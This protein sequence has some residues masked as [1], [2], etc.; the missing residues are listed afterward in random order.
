MTI[1]IWAIIGVGLVLAE[2]AIPGLILVFLG[3]GALTVALLMAAGDVTTPGVQFTVFG[4]TS[5]VYLVAL[6]KFFQ[7]W[8][9]GRFE[10]MSDG[11]GIVDRLEGQR[12]EVLGEFKAGRGRVLLNGVKWDAESADVLDE[13]DSAIIESKDGIRLRVRKLDPA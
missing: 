11:S 3:M 6:R 1:E 9:K 12:V 2:F 5:V 4:V 10:D 13:G 8:L 7:R